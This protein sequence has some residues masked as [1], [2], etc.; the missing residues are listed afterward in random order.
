MALIIRIDV[1][2]PY[3]KRPLPRHIFSRLC[4]DLYFPKVQA[5]GYLD[6]LKQMLLALNER[7]ARAY[8]FFRQC[9]LPPASILKL[10][11]DGKH[12]VGLH[13][14]D[15]RSFETFL[16]EKETLER[17]V[18]RPVFAVSKHGSGKVKYGSR[19]HAPYEPEKYQ[20]WA[21][22][23][24]MKTV[25]GNLEDPT[26]EQIRI[27]GLLFFPSAF[28]LEPYWR[29]TARFS[30]DWLLANAPRRDTVMLVHPENVLESPEITRSF[31]HLVT[32]LETRIL[33]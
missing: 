16:E 15:S 2:R 10:V 9:T 3:G 6:E 28:W 11:D 4:S 32:H 31:T 8:V 24:Q 27:G 5:L 29:D 22:R 25:F 1:D 26:I 33:P 13:L 19:H 18:G 12:E 20:Q 7:K 21:R 30:E 14:E 17:H 23:T